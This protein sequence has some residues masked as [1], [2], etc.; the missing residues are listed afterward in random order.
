MASVPVLMRRLRRVPK[1]T[2][3]PVSVGR[4]EHYEPEYELIFEAV[5]DC[6]GEEALDELGEWAIAWTKRQQRLPTPA[7]MRERTREICERRRV[8]VPDYSPL[9]G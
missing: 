6:A 2:K 8:E 1:E 7:A 4:Y 3:K 5:D 9:L